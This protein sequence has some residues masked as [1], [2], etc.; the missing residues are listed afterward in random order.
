M[1]DEHDEQEYTESGAPIYRHK[2]RKEEFSPAFGDC[3][4]IEAISSHINQYVGHPA[5]V[6]HELISDLV[7]IDVH[8]VKPTRKHNFHTL[9]TSGMSDLPM[10]SPEPSLEYAEVMI[11][12]PSEWKLSE[13]DFEDENN[14]WPIRLLKFL[15]R[16]PHEYET[17]LYI[18]HSVPNYDPPEPF[19]QNTRFCGSLIMPPVL[20]GDGFG[21]LETNGKTIHF[22]SVVPIYAE[23]MDYKLKKGFDALVDRLDKNQVTE[24]LDLKRKNT[25]K[26]FL[27]LF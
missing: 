2:E 9:I 10:K 14:Y 12:L 4:N 11:A 6:F 19:A 5:M 21:K 1:F 16:F 18:S 25:C 20:F 26:K 24:L 17:W 7:H 8:W 23:E 3:E 22:L 15:A 27:G 13:Q